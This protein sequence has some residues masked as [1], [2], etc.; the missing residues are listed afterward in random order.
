MVWLALQKVKKGIRVSD[1]G[2]RD[3]EEIL[4]QYGMKQI[5]EGSIWEKQF[6]QRS[7][8]FFELLFVWKTILFL[9]PFLNAEE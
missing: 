4:G 2:V 5:G 7:A 8:Q 6:V 3:Q 9:P 1:P